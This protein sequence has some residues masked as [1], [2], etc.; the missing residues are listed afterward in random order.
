LFIGPRELDLFNDIS[1]EVM[2]DIAGQQVHLYPIDYARTMVHDVYQE[3]PE[4][5]FDTPITID[6]RVTWQPTEVTTNEFGHDEIRTIEVFVHVRDMLERGVQVQTG[7]FL[8]FGESFY[9]ITSCV[10][11]DVVFGMP[12]YRMGYKMTCV[13][14]RQDEFV[15]R[16]V[17]PTWEGFSEDDAVKEDFYQQR[18]FESNQE[19]A[20]GD[21]RDLVRKGALEKPLGGPRE[22]SR[23]GSDIADDSSFYDEPDGEPQE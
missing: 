17:G 14:T 11:S 5:V 21:V 19:G 23:R 7:D 4:R 18:G 13:Q 9:E 12:E 8:S 20:T 22:V 2:K 10:F 6:A 15:A 3:A 16:I 1:R